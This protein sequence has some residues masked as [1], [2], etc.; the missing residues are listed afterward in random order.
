MSKLSGMGSLEVSCQYSMSTEPSRSS[1]SDSMFV[2]F[3][4][5]PKQLAS[6][7][8]TTRGVFVLSFTSHLFYA[9]L[10][11]TSSCEGGLKRFFRKEL[12][13]CAQLA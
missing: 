1:S 8:T 11:A 13:Q 6:P 4:W 7:T 9:T 2:R 10:E 3:I 12:L 5:Q